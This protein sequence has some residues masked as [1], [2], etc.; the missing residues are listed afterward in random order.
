VAKGFRGNNLGLVVSLLLYDEIAPWNGVT[1]TYSTYSSEF[2]LS[3]CFML[4]A[5]I[6]LFRQL[7]VSHILNYR[8]GE[9]K[10]QTQNGA[11]FELSSDIL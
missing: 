7:V 8:I 1:R 5:A 4:S 6:V 3:I 2:A 11:H 10:V 9:P